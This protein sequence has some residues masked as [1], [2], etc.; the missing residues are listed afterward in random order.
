MSFPGPT[1]SLAPTRKPSGGEAHERR[2]IT[3]RRSLMTTH[4]HI[5]RVVLTGTS[6]NTPISEA[7][8]TARRSAPWASRRAAAARRPPAAARS[9]SPTTSTPPC[10][11]PRA[12][13]PARYLTGGHGIGIDEPLDERGCQPRTAPSAAPSATRASRRPREFSKAPHG[14]KQRRPTPSVA[15][16]PALVGPTDACVDSRPLRCSPGVC[17]R[18]WAGSLAAKTLQVPGTPLSS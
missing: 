14:H 12:R 18:T 16:V 4:E 10:S 13:L 6:P 2:P 3:S 7:P 15:R 8:G 11:A 1:T 5:Y 9:T 17:R